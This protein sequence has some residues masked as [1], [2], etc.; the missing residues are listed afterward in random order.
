[1]NDI[2]IAIDKKLEELLP[3]ETTAPALLHSAMRYSVFSG[4]KRIRPVFCIAT[5]EALGGSMEKALVSACAIEL[6]HTYT[7][8][9]DDLP[10]MDDDDMRRG[11]PSC[12]KQ[13]NEAT[14]ILAGDA[15]L[16]LAF[17]LLGTTGNADF[18]V[19]LARATGSLGVIGGQQ[20]DM[21]MKD[22]V[23]SK[24]ALLEMQRKKTALLFSVS[25]VIG[26]RCANATE[27]QIVNAKAFGQS[28]GKAFQLLDDICDNDAVTMNVIGREETMKLAEEYKAESYRALA[29]FLPLTKGELE[30]VSRDEKKL[31]QLRS[32][33]DF[34]Y[35]SFKI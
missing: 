35:A 10:A 20:D 11:M 26:A 24:E 30:G 8:I 14:A 16:T 4:G 9:H 23:P 15:L 13:F 28:L 33:V 5:C 22:N 32:I 31:D 19:D 12:H 6:L 29:S 1:M 34:T 7:L 18:I 2:I 27:E 17:E 3:A 25:C 21:S